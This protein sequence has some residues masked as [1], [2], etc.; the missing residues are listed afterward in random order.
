M[1]ANSAIWILGGSGDVGRRLAAVLSETTKRSVVLCGRDG[2][3]ADA[4]AKE[5]GGKVEGRGLDVSNKDVAAQVPPGSSIV[6]LTES[7]H[8]D[9]AKSAVLTGGIFVESAATPAYVHSISQA[10]RNDGQGLVIVHAGLMPG[11]SNVLADA[12]RKNISE[13]TTVDVVIEMGMGRHYGA[14]ATR[15]IIKSLG[16]TYDLLVD[17]AVRKVRPGY[18]HRSVVFEEESSERPALGFPFSTQLDVTTSGIQEI[19]SFLAI[20]PSWL[21]RLVSLALKLGI[22]S[23]LAN[24]DARVERI[25]RIL[26]VTGGTQTRLFVEGLDRN[27][28]PVASIQVSSGDQADI[29][30]AM[31]A[32]TLL[33]AE[34]SMRRGLAE[35]SDIMPPDRALSAVERTSPDTRIFFSSDAAIDSILFGRKTN[36]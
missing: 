24:V 23:R 32:E 3:K 6:N 35:A 1:I 36:E 17:G 28:E 5:I 34:K 15:W 12:L 4:V 33:A 22:G 18:L 27:G 25:L 8:P 9:I 20:K 2:H 14:A 21:T 26:P 11:L 16:S 29:T 13:I 31:L 30:A 10:A 19:R 7:A